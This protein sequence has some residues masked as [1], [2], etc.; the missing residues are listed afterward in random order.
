MSEILLAVRGA[1]SQ[2]TEH[3][4]TKVVR[5]NNRLAPVIVCSRQLSSKNGICL[6]MSIFSPHGPSCN[7]EK[8]IST[9]L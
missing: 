3:I 8:R 6:R 2:N 7:I 5:I 9:V 1:L 4:C